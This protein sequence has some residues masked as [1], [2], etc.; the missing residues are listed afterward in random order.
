MNVF[1]LDFAIN[2][3]IGAKACYL[4]KEKK[5]SPVVMNSLL[6]PSREELGTSQQIS[7]LALYF[8]L[9]NNCMESFVKLKFV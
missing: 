6:V 7:N 4:K 8:N 2:I 9:N 5:I 3:D 1:C